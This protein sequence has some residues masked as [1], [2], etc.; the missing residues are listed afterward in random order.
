MKNFAPFSQF[1]QLLV[2]RCWFPIWIWYVSGLMFINL[3]LFNCCS[4]FILMDDGFASWTETH[5]P[6]LSSWE[7]FSKSNS[8]TRGSR[9]FYHCRKHCERHDR[10]DSKWHQVRCTGLLCFICLK[11]MSVKITADNL[12]TMF[13]SLPGLQRRVGGFVSFSACLQFAAAPRVV[14][15]VVVLTCTLF[16]LWRLDVSVCSA[17]FL[18]L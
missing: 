9:R 11:L 5:F 14:F 12:T 6:P 16:L 13:L 2:S 17:C 10:C 4:I 18:Y 15:R 7:V 1:P 8:S 3:R